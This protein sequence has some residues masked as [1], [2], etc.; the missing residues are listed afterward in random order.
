[1]G[2]QPSIG[3]Y[4]FGRIEIDG[5]TYHSDVI[6]LPTGVRA[7]WWREE[8]HAL[9]PQDL[10]P[11]L[12]AAPEVLVIGQGAHGLMRVADETLASL[13]EAEIEAVYAP[14]RQAVEVYNERCQRGQR[15]AAA[16]H[17]TC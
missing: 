17:L 16:L 12:D 2:R 3:A 1:M 14:T 15:V 7:N 10:T 8:G 13:R 11:V 5:R 9:R 4:A 6:V